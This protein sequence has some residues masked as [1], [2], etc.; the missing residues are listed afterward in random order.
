MPKTLVETKHYQIANTLQNRI[1]R[2]KP[3]KSIATIQ[4]LSEE[5]QVADKTVVQ[6]LE[7]LKHLNY[8]YKPTGKQRYVVADK[9]KK[10]LKS[11][12]MV[13]P[14]YPSANYE[15][16]TK[17][18]MVAGDKLSW[19][20]S[21]NAYTSMKEVQLN[22]VFRGKYD[23]VLFLP[24][25]EEFPNDVLKAI[26]RPRRPVIVLQQH[27]NNKS[28]CSVSV[29][30]YKIGQLAAEHLLSLGHRKCL[31]LIDQNI[32]STIQ[33]RVDGWNATLKASGC[34]LNSSYVLNCDV[35]SGQD[36]ISAT[37]KMASKWLDGDAPDF[38][39]VFTTSEAGAFALLRA[40]RERNIDVPA[41]V[42]IITYSGEASLCQYMHPEV[43]AIEISSDGYGEQVTK[44]LSENFDSTIQKCVL[45]I[46]P[47]LAIRNSTAAFMQSENRVSVQ[48]NILFTRT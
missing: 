23:A 3:N 9:T 27:L 15:S 29:N 30:D 8:I 41:E 33:Q 16:M 38:S 39:A 28:V 32:D 26:E 47:K 22:N 18:I 20:F 37:Y 4:Q 42:N 1:R 34:V 44:L 11:I 48:E 17:S 19:E 45:Q 21:I 7:R 14:T 46:E 40:F 36:S 24:T 43:T 12:V 31:L 13:R 35:K 6:S 25:N 10:Y 2:L 5:F